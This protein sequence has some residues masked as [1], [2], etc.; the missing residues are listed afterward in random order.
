MRSIRWLSF[1]SL[2]VP[3]RGLLAQATPP[4]PPRSPFAVTHVTVVDVTSGAERADQT[5]LVI[6]DRIQRL[7]PAGRVRV[8]DAARSVDGRGAY[9]VPGLW[10]MHTHLVAF[11][12][13]GMRL[14]IANGVTGVRDM[15]GSFDR[16][17][18]WRS[19]IAA[20]ALIGPRVRMA[21]PMLDDLRGIPGSPFSKV[22]VSTAEAA[23]RAVDSVQALGVDFIKVHYVSRP[24]YLAI[25]AEARARRIPFAGHVPL[26]ATL[27]EV[28]RA[29]PRSI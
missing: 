26:D 27:E 23:R 13:L 10:D 18:E 29:G 22:M 9:L 28:V 6:G 25:A 17:R 4:A 2:A 11:G 8:P 19:R 16:L 24:V 21:G 5:V 1:M 20:G 15:G 3:A 12:E 7:G 14:M